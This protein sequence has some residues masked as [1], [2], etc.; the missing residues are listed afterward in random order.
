M[1]ERIYI[2]YL[3]DSLGNHLKT[4]HAKV[5]STGHQVDDLVDI[6]ICAGNAH[7]N[8]MHAS[9]LDQNCLP[10]ATCVLGGWEVTQLHQVCPMTKDEP[11]V[12]HRG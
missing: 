1:R 4:R 3:N 11:A 7:V 9:A 2:S 6:E 12:L 8:F 5:H 10:L